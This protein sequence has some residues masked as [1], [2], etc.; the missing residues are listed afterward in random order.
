MKPIYNVN[1]TEIL[2]TNGYISQRWIH[3][4]I[5]KY[6]LNLCLSVPLVTYTGWHRPHGNNFQNSIIALNYETKCYIDNGDNWHVTHCVLCPSWNNTIKQKFQLGSFM[7]DI[8]S[9][10]FDWIQV[11]RKTWQR[12]KWVNVW[13]FHLQC[14]DLWRWLSLVVE[15]F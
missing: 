12:I 2:T 1:K 15:T 9:R 6:H 14:N 4:S 10:F 3:L 5:G 13:W 11:D 7:F 8:S